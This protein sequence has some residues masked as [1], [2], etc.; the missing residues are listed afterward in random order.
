MASTGNLTTTGRIFARNTAQLVADN[1]NNLGGRIHADSVVASAKTDINNIAGTISAGHELIATAGRDINV[2]TT[3][4]SASS[5]VGG[6]QFS[7]T[8]IDGI[9][10][11]AV[12]GSG[13][14]LVA[15]AG[16][17][18]NLVAAKIE[19][20]GTDGNTLLDAGH[21]LNLGT[22]TTASSNKQEIQRLH[23]REASHNWSFFI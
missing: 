8:T 6:N 11:L 10:S 20:G 4:R 7:R 19:N 15:S 14:T 5:S 1:I 22:V 16:R 21:N 13:G 18:I 9:G 17:D 3:T 12:T 23:R 2:E